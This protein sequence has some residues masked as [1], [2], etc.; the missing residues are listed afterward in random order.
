MLLT[1]PKQEMVHQRAIQNILHAAGVDITPP[2][3]YEFP[4]YNTSQFLVLGRKLSTVA[5]GAAVALADA[6]STLDPELVS[7]F[8]SIAATE[9]RLSAFFEVINGHVPNPSPFDTPVAGVW[10]Y[11][12]ALNFV[13]SG[14]CQQTL[15]L[16]I[17]PRLTAQVNETDVTFSWDPTQEPLIREAGRPLFIGWVNQLGPPI[18]TPLDVVNI[19]T[20]TAK[21]PGG[22]KGGVYAALTAQNNLATADELAETTLAGPA[23]VMP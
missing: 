21:L 6:I 13:I 7:G 20:G 2:C 12:L 8:A 11:N 17:L 5:V 4:S 22:F 23:V 1:V 15:P 3:Q 10:A 16:P 14:S 9:A 18:Y 19:G